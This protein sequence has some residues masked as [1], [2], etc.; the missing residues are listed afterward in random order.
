[1]KQ[2]VCK[3][4]S[5]VILGLAGSGGVAAA[6]QTY[7]MIVGYPPGGGGDNMVRVL[8]QA[9]A[10]EMKTPFVVEN[11]P[12]A[13]GAIAASY[14]KTAPADGSIIMFV[15]QHVMGTLP[16][17]MKAPPYDPIK[18]FQSIGQISATRNAIVISANPAIRS[19]NDWIASARSNPAQRLYGVPS[20]GTPPEFLG[21]KLGRELKIDLS[22]VPYKGNSPMIVEL[23]G[24]QLQVGI[25]TL[26]D[27][28]QYHQ[29]GRLRVLAV[30]GKN[31]D[32][33]A[34]DVPTLGELGY[35]NFEG[36]SWSGL[37]VRAGTPADQV[38]RLEAALAN[39]M[40]QP[41]IREQFET[42]GN[43]LVYGNAEELQKQI[44]EGMQFW[45][46]LIKTS[47]FTLN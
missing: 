5:A 37:V 16:L 25:T 39:V 35:A 6:P 38:K 23:L 12:G 7:R 44:N 42:S 27:L 8:A 34:P 14:V 17:T 10:I 29:A 15:N 9:L 31:R 36:L 20:P 18:D 33:S 11:R 43:P 32:P 13:G 30:T 19:F 26:P 41:K 28:L 47:G 46:D 45:R 24:G 3:V 40:A 22:S 1:M 4:L 21:F 2:L